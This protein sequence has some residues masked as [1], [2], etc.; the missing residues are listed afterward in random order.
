MQAG[1]PTATA[2][3][4]R[5]DV[6]AA[7]EAEVADAVAALLAAASHDASTADS[8]CQLAATVQANDVSASAQRRAQEAAWFADAL[9]RRDLR[10][11]LLGGADDGVA[12]VAF[13]LPPSAADSI[14]MRA[15]T[16]AQAAVE[17]VDATELAALFG[18]GG[19][20][21]D[22]DP[23]L[24]AG[25]V[26]ALSRQLRAEQ[27]AAASAQRETWA[28]R[29]A[30][31]AK[32]SAATREA[33]ALRAAAQPGSGQAVQG[34]G[35]GHGAAGRGGTVLAPQAVPA[36]GDTAPPVDAAAPSTQVSEGAEADGKPVARWISPLGRGEDAAL[37]SPA[38]RGAM[39]G[40]RV[41]RHLIVACGT[42][43]GGRT[44]AEVHALCLPSL[45]WLRLPGGPTARS[46]HSLCALG[47][48]AVL[49]GGLDAASR[50][51]M[52][53]VHAL[54]LTGD[55]PVRGKWEALEPRG[56]GPKPSLFHAAC[57]TE[58]GMLVHGGI[59]AP[60]RPA[61]SRA[62]LLAGASGRESVRERDPL[63]PSAP[64]AGSL[65]LR[66]LAVAA[67]VGSRQ[68]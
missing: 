7:P 41:G 46:G 55:S 37:D 42:L 38:P 58:G 56:R 29:D 5:W 57:A 9:C 62:Y 10:S 11:R 67:P 3:A 14:R 44:C 31:R 36:V 1:S 17:G 19:E 52:S 40:C 60:A 20:S 39:A 43:A 61:R 50:R 51:F 8:L 48:S 6:E 28:L 16:A 68:L 12:G 18:A 47:S 65:T 33:T 32:D 53:D 30:L 26:R 54:R 25:A 13:D 24:A 22:V 34:N 63:R 23:A 45:R 64:H 4:Q 27:R 49:F 66:S 59:V 35:N 21:G 2:A 15:D